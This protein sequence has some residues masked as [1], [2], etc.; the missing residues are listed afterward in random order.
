MPLAGG[1][2]EPFGRCHRILGYAPA[3]IIEL[4]ED[5]FG[6]GIAGVCRLFEKLEG[7]LD[8]LRPDLSLEI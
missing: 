1:V 4:R 5:V 7:V 6:V 8:V 3:V 2:G